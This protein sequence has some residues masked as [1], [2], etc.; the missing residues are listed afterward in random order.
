VFLKALS[1]RGVQA[2]LAAALLFGAGTPLAKLLLG[3]DV[4][5]WLLAGLLC[6]G[7]GVGLGILRLVR[8]A[9]RLRLPRRDLVPLAGAILSGGVIAP[10]LLMLGLSQMPASGASLLLN[11]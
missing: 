1:H 11:A 8:R 10:V 6:C 9:P 4:S 3:G 7:S 2:A 5:P